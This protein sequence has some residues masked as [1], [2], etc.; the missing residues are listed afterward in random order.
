MKPIILHKIERIFGNK[1]R[2]SN[3]VEN[4]IIVLDGDKRQRFLYEI[5]QK[6]GCDVQFCSEKELLEKGIDSKILIGKTPFLDKE[7]ISLLSQLKAGQIFL[8]GV[9]SKEVKEN[10]VKNGVLVFDFMKQQTVAIKNSVATAEGV[11]AEIILKSDEVIRESVITVLGYGICGKTI[12]TLLKG[13]GVKVIVCARKKETRI[14]A[15]IIADEVFSIE[16]MEQGLKKSDIVVNTIPD[17]IIK[18]NELKIL[19]KGCIIIDIASY[20]GGV[21]YEKAEELGVRAYLCKGLPAIYSPKN[22][23]QILYEE[24]KEQGFLKHKKENESYFGL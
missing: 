9:I 2:M 11:V 7:Q 24:M 15:K 23:A 17:K 16:E 13:M 20:P 14:E 12:T 10:L 21:D 8:A 1:R 22:S 6:E 5:L 18:E 3:V 4:K 19:K